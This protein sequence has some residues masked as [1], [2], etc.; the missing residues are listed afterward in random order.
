[1]LKR[2]LLNCHRNWLL[3]LFNY[4]LGTYWFNDLLKRLLTLFNNWLGILWHDLLDWLRI[5]CLLGLFGNSKGRLLLGNLR[6][7]RH[8]LDLFFNWLHDL[9]NRRRFN[10]NLPSLFNQL[11]RLFH[12]CLNLLWLLNLFRNRWR[13]SLLNNL[14][15]CLLFLFNNLLLLN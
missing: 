1:L 15:R 11:L 8:L 6:N 5:C 2:L 12:I 14:N 13:L 9:L 7:L 3:S 4:R 10:K